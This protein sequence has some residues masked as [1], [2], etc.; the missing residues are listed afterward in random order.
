MPTEPFSGASDRR[1]RP[2]WKFI[3]AAQAQRVS[4]EAAWLMWRTIRPKATRSIFNA[5]WQDV[6]E[7]MN[8][9]PL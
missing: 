1:W 3:E 2:I 6:T 9:A 4:R 8:G 5:E 7:W